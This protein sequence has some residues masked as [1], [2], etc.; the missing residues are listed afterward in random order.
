[1][2]HYKLVGN[3]TF[4]YI[5]YY[6]LARFRNDQLKGDNHSLNRWVPVLRNIQRV[7]ISV[8]FSKRGFFSHRRENAKITNNE[9]NR[10]IG[11]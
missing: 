5:F 3:V 4:V 6:L 10:I 2:I 1:M 7:N 8:S 9:V 11:K